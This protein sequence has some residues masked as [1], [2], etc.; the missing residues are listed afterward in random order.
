MQIWWSFYSLFTTLQWFPMA[1]VQIALQSTK[2]L[3]GLVPESLQPHFWHLT[4][5]FPQTDH[6]HSFSYSEV[7]QAVA[8]LCVFAHVFL[9]PNEWWY[10]FSRPNTADTLFWHYPSSFPGRAQQ[11]FPPYMSRLFHKAYCIC[12]PHKAWDVMG[13]NSCGSCPCGAYSL[14]QSWQL[15]R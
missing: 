13:R 8:F 12:V 15:I 5:P 1:K 3:C 6:T 2:A 9:L 11:S 7:R 10:I 14:I 4:V